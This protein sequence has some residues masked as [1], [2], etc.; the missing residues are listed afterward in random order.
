MEK[1][2]SLIPLDSIRVARPC[3]QS[4]EGM[5]GDGAVRHCQTCRKNVHNLSLMTRAEAE[6]FVND[7]KGE[8]ACVYFYR[9][10]DGT[11]LTED[12]PVGL[13]EARRPLPWIV[14]SFVGLLAA[15]GVIVAQQHPAPP[16][17][18]QDV[19]V[20]NSGWS[21]S[22]VMTAVRQWL[23]GAPPVPGG[24]IS[25]GGGQIATST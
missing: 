3:R 1:N 13:R 9:R 18:P 19:A 5:E 2:Q 20:A 10:G 11:L 24:F 7:L 12:C 17:L 6:R 15:G 16:P 14:A 8:K 21:A 4:W 25:Y 22:Q 23:Y